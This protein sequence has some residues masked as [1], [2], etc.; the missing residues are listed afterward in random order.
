MMR[1]F[2]C[3]VLGLLM[4]K[5]LGGRLEWKEERSLKVYS[6]ILYVTRMILSPRIS[7]HVTSINSR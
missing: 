7:V 4:D 6:V 1:L 2:S 5:V 3:L